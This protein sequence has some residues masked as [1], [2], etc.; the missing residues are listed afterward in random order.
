LKAIEASAVTPPENVAMT[1]LVDVA[2]VVGV[3]VMVPVVKLS[4][5]PAGRLFLSKD[6]LLPVGT[7]VKVIGV[8]AEPTA[9]FTLL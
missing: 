1:V 8:I 6:G 3:P 2:A 4:V 5:K 7:T 9:P